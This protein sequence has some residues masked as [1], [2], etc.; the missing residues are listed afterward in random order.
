MSGPSAVVVIPLPVAP[1][2][3]HAVLVANVNVA[4]VVGLARGPVGNVQGLHGVGRGPVEGAL[5]VTAHG[6]VE[7]A[8]S[9]PPV[10]QVVALAR[11]ID[12]MWT[13]INVIRSILKFTKGS[14]S[15]LMTISYV[16]QIKALMKDNRIYSFYIGQNIPPCIGPVFQTPANVPPWPD[17]RD[18]RQR[19]FWPRWKSGK[20]VDRLPTPR[21]NHLEGVH[22]PRRPLRVGPTVERDQSGWS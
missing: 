20:S 10:A 12:L 2:H 7:V 18:P 14:S 15:H 1:V 4:E 6:V 21:Q 3:L 9:E 8:R 19:T 22:R 11:E 16:S 17:M 5:A 13:S